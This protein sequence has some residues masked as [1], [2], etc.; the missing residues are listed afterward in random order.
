M[1]V[2]NKENMP[3]CGS[4]TRKLLL[5]PTPPF[6]FLLFNRD[7][8]TF[9]NSQIGRKLGFETVDDNITI[10]GREC[11]QRLILMHLWA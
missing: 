7:N 3:Q 2:V 8:N 10:Q 1:E 9:S 4:P 6:D 11:S 5:V